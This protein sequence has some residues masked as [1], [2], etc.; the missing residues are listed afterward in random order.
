[1]RDL[2]AQFVEELPDGTRVGLEGNAGIITQGGDKILPVNGAKLDVSKARRNDFLAG[3]L[4]ADAQ[5][6]PVIGV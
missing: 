5:R 6:S 2:Q 4:K 1:L 3:S